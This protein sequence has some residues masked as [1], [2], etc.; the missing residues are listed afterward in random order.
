MPETLLERSEKAFPNADFGQ[1]YGMS[2][3][4]SGTFLTPGDHRPGPQLRSAGR[5][6]I[7]T[8]LRV[9]D[10]DDV[11]V[12]TGA[13]GEI[14]LRGPGSMLGYWNDPDATAEVLRDGWAHTGDV[15]YLDESG[16]VYVVDRVKDTI[17]VNGD[18]VHSVEVENTLAAHPDVAACAVIAVPD[19]DVGERVHAV[20]VARSGSAPDAD[21]LRTHCASRIADFKIPTGWEFVEVLP[22]SPTGKVLKR[23]LRKPHWEGMA[24]QVN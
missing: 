11:D 13:L 18:N 16:Y 20:V 24:R 4:M 17:V 7:H 6:A 5:A 15:G 1:L 12:P 14:L 2:E 19:G 10:S 3:T 21:E 9:V 23:D 8:E 22:T